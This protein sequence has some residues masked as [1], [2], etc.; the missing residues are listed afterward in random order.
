LLLCSVHLA[1]D[2]LLESTSVGID[3]IVDHDQT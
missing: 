3:G 2:I 1:N